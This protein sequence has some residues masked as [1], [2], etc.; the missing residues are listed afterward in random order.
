MSQDSGFLTIK[1]ASVMMR[2]HRQT[3]YQLV[4]KKKFKAVRVGGNWRIS[5]NHIDKLTK[6]GLV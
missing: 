5:L 2:I 6:S 3:M 1:E 4:K